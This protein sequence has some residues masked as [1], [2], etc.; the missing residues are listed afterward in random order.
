MVP[1]VFGKRNRSFHVEADGRGKNVSTYKI[2]LAGNPN[3]CLIKVEKQKFR[4]LVDSGADI[5][6][7]R[8]DVY[9]S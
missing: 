1:R 6:L 5:S 7:I 2:C 8:W 3:S 4:A 9:D